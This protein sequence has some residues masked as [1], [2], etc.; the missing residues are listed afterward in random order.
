MVR[1]FGKQTRTRTTRSK[2]EPATSAAEPATPPAKTPPGPPMKTGET[3]LA[4]KKPATRVRR[5]PTRPP[6]RDWAAEAAAAP[7][8]VPAPAPTSLAT[9]PGDDADPASAPAK[10]RRGTRGGRGR[11][12][13]GSVNGDSP[14]SLSQASTQREVSRN[15]AEPLSLEALVAEQG[16]VLERFAHDVS[17]TLG[18]LQA[19]IADLQKQLASNANAAGGVAGAT[20]R[21]GIFVDVPNVIYAAERRN[22]NIDFGR[23]LDYFTRGRQLV[24]A[25]AYAPISD[26]PQAKLESQRFVHQFVGHPYRIITKP[27]KRFA[28]GSMKANFD[29]E[30]AIDILTMSDRLDVVVLMSGDGDF[31]RLV[32]MISSRGVR[33]EVV[34]FGET[35]SNELK[36]V[37]D[38]YIEIGAHLDEF[39]AK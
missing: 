39:K 5:A 16:R 17:S 12:K 27:L 26:D 30:L 15:G 38:L 6:R 8:D 14:A 24:R 32:E 28:D 33:V 10:R 7:A 34:A 11:K 35:A 9:T 2:Q 1:F 18:S 31:R 23:V 4:E 29:I 21:V 3:N 22:I 36:A 13:P 25:S 19:T 20:Q 37:A